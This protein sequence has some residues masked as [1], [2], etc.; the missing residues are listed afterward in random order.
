MPR[1]PLREL[2][3]ARQDPAGYRHRMMQPSGVQYRPSYF[4]ALRDAIARFHRTDRV[5]ARTYLGQRLNTFRNQVKQ[6]ETLDRFDWY[7]QDTVQRGWPTFT[8]RTNLAIVLPPFVP[9]DVTCTG[10]VARIDLV[11]SGGYAAWILRNGVIDDWKEELQM[12]LIQE[13]LAT[14]VLHVEPSSIQIGIYAFRGYQVDVKLFS[15]V[16]IQQARDQL[17]AL[18]RS[19]GF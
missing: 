18:L 1:I 12:P 15:D 10:Q 14:Q 5:T 3:D 8:S 11:P 7:V 2:E 16:E 9:G 17:T 4:S 13:A 19:M 6:R